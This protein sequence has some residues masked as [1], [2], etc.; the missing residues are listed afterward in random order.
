MRWESLETMSFK[1]FLLEHPHLLPEFD[2]KKLSQ[3][4]TKP[5]EDLTLASFDDNFLGSLAISCIPDKN[6]IKDLVLPV[7]NYHKKHLE[8]TLNPS[9]LDVAMCFEVWSSPKN[10]WLLP[11]KSASRCPKVP[12]MFY[13]LRK[14][15][16]VCNLSS[17]QFR[18]EKGLTWGRQQAR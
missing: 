2:V 18:S 16:E 17:V 7:W 6:F 14:A 8:I 10:G 15:G 13:P 4:W 1:I 12:S 3:R 5:R 9:L 11:T